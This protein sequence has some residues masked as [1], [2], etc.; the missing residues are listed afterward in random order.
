MQVSL[1][2]WML[3]VWF[4]CFSNVDGGVLMVVLLA[5]V[6]SA[7]GSGSGSSAPT[8]VPKPKRKP[9]LEPTPRP[10][11]APRQSSSPPTSPQSK[12]LNPKFRLPK[13]SFSRDEQR[14]KTMLVKVQI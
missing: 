7:P 8:A 3:L 5:V 14:R 11:P 12:L 10:S 13:S 1:S 6:V 4:V 9:K 2:Y